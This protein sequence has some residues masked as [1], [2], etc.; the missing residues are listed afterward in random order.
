MWIDEL[1][2]RLIGGDGSGDYDDQYDGDTRNVLGTSVTV[3]E[4]PIRPAL[5]E[6]ER[7]PEWDS[8]ACVT[9][10]D[11]R[12]SITCT[13]AVIPSPMSDTLSAQMPRSLL[14]RTESI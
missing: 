13:M 9:E 6:R 4:A 12:T 11:N 14:S 8:G 7:H 3:G 1:H 5:Y 2:D 10:P